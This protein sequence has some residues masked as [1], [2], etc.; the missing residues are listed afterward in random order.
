MQ[1]LATF[2]RPGGMRQEED[3]PVAGDMLPASS[4]VKDLEPSMPVEEGRPPHAP[5]SHREEVS[6]PEAHP[7][8][9]RKPS[10]RKIKQWKDQA[11]ERVSLGLSAVLEHFRRVSGDEGFSY[12][13]VPLLLSDRGYKLASRAEAVILRD[14]GMSW[15]KIAKE[16]NQRSLPAPDKGKW[17]GPKL[18]A[19][20]EAEYIL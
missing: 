17:T 9:T 12:A 2:Y 11:A 19:L 14:E 4:P 1:G 3:V 6:A 20:V 16:F 5:P 7:V 13:S 15:P 10:A 8:R 18:R